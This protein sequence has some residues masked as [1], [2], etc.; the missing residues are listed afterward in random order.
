MELV[1][2]RG[3]HTNDNLLYMLHMYVC[4]IIIASLILIQKISNIQFW[5]IDSAN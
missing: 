2:L 3:N 1:Q 5:H 4:Y